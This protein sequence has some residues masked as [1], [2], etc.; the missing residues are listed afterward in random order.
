MTNIKNGRDINIALKDIRTMGGSV[1]L[2]VGSY[3]LRETVILDTPSSCLEGEVW[4]YNLDPNGVFETPYGT[5]LRLMG[6]SFPALSVGVGSVPAGVTVRN[7][8]I[9]GDI[10][11]MDTRPLLDINNISASAGLYFGGQRVDQGEFTKISCCGLSVA[12]CAAAEAELDACRF[13]KINMDGCCIG[14][15][16]APEA[17]YYTRFSGCVVADTPSYGFFSD[18]TGRLIHNL[19]IRDNLF[20]RNC[21]GGPSLSGAPAAVYLKSISDCAFRDN[22]VDMAGEFWYY[23]DN[24]VS[25]DERQITKGVAVGLMVEGHRNRISGNTFS[26]SSGESIVIKGNGNILMNN[27]SD[28]DVII[29][30]EGNIVNGLVFTTAD[31]RLVLKGAASTTTRILGVEKERVICCKE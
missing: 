12:V 26:H 3:E 22:L 24:A 25:N 21:G 8:G 18:G 17:S 14:V 20:I 11:G 6:R 16:F 30:G 2:G 9:Q 31:A 23:S 7:I 19:D 4:A 5:K 28:S 27:I 1:R 10:A 15:Y 29:D 13:E